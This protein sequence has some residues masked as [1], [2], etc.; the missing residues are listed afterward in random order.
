MGE[1]GYYIGM[2]LQITC[3]YIFIY[4]Y[5]YMCIY[6]YIC[7]YKFTR[8]AHNAKYI[9]HAHI[10]IYNYIYIRIYLVSMASLPMYYVVCQRIHQ[11]FPGAIRR[12]FTLGAPLS[13][14]KDVRLIAPWCSGRLGMCAG[15]F[16]A[17]LIVYKCITICIDIFSIN[18]VLT[19][20]NSVCLIHVL[21]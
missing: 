2:I 3:M 14:L 1:H 11:R 21:K 19:D 10:Y 6:M 16:M 17:W 8:N 7:I 12:C 18:S 5:V 15:L 9:T 20:I 4:I 13:G